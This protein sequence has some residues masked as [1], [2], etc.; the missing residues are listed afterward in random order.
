MSVNRTDV[1]LGIA[2]QECPRILLWTGLLVIVISTLTWLEGPDQL[3]LVHAIDYAVAVFLLA[4]SW[5]IS[6]DAV[7]LVAVPW[8]FALGVVAVQ[9]AFVYEVHLEQDTLVFAYLI[10]IMTGFGPTT[11][12]WRPFLAGAAAMTIALSFLSISWGDRWADWLIVGLTALTVGALL[13]HTR[14]RG[15]DALADASE[16]VRRLAVTDELT[17]LLNRHGLMAQ[18]PRLTAMARRQQT[19]LFAVFVDIDGLKV[20]NDRFGHAFGDDV[21]QMAGESVLGSVR[22]GDLVA[23]WGGDEM[24]IVGIGRHPD[25]AS[26][27]TR[28]DE[29][30]TASGIDRSRWPGHLSVGFAQGD[31]ADIP[32]DELI[33]RAD[34]DMYGRRGN[35]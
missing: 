22:G 16:Q 21:I 1:R 19:A 24:V 27:S 32:I 12:A 20:A 23:R 9:V 4:L 5:I 15:I 28:L 35:R 8:V 25:P 31:D 29:H 17:G 10:I 2:R 30:V 14:L 11:L 34:A 18:V 7:P 13:L 3:I 6:R 26:F 33:D